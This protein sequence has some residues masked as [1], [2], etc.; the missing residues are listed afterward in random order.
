VLAHAEG[1]HPHAEAVERVAE[2]VLGDGHARQQHHALG[3]ERDFLRRS[4][5]VVGFLRQN[6]AVGV[7]RLTGLAQPGDRP[8]QLFDLG[9]RC[10]AQAAEVE[11]HREHAIVRAGAIEGSEYVAQH[12]GAFALFERAQRAQAIGQWRLLDEV[13]VERER[14]YEA[15][16]QLEDRF[17][18]A[19]EE[20]RDED[21]HR[22]ADGD[23]AKEFDEAQRQQDQPAQRPPQGAKGAKTHGWTP[24]CGRGDGQWKFGHRVTRTDRCLVSC[25]EVRSFMGGC[26]H[27]R[28]FGAAAID[29]IP[30][31]MPQGAAA[32]LELGLGAPGRPLGGIGVDR[33]QARFGREHLF[34]PLGVFFPVGGAVQVAAGSEPLGG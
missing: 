22:E 27:G 13:A 11:R 17:P 7:Y 21:E 34:H 20:R 4:S 25:R 15:R 8:A 31:A 14:E 23:P 2:I 3:V 5:E 28:R 29:E 33:F 10:S 26:L 19:D 1:V 32:A 16:R 9:K 12:D 24:P 30:H 18:L 6:V